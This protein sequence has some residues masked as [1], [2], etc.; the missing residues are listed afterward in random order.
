MKIENLNKIMYVFHSS[1]YSEKSMVSYSQ[2]NKVSDNF[3]L[4]FLKSK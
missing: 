4:T 3:T 2:I 1:L